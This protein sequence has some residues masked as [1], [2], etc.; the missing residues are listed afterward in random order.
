[1]NRITLH[2]I[3]SKDKHTLTGAQL[4]LQGRAPFPVGGEVWDAGVD[5]FILS[6]TISATAA[7]VA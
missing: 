4:F 5:F 7:Y 2:N 3:Y 1:L 6:P